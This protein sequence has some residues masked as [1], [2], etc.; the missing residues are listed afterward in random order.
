VGLLVFL[1]STVLER[2]T[3]SPAAMI[4]GQGEVL[5]AQENKVALAVDRA[6]RITV[7]DRALVAVGQEAWERVVTA[8]LVAVVL[9]VEILVI[10]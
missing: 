4:F 2:L 7:V 5:E 8:F 6:V 1:V 9:T 3:V 10:Q